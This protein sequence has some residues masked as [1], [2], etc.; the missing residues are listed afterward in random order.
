M[1]VVSHRSSSPV[2]RHTRPNLVQSCVDGDIAGVRRALC[3]GSDPNGKTRGQTPLMFA[4]EQGHADICALLIQNGAMVNATDTYN[5]TALH[6]ACKRLHPAVCTVL[7]EN[8]AD[9][10]IP[11]TLGGETPSDIVGMRGTIEISRAV[12]W[13]GRDANASTPSSPQRAADAAAA[14]ESKAN[15]PPV[16]AAAATPSSP[17]ADESKPDAVVAAAPQPA[18]ADALPRRPPAP[19]MADTKRCHTPPKKEL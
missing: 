2:L 19:E 16:A 10:L 14:V 7:M 18:T 8:G 9:R 3:S 11:S 5:Q 1:A 4:A 12:M 13:H 17:A 6:F 15:V